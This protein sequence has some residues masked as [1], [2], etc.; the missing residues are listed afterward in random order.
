[1]AAKKGT[2]LFK[3]A[4]QINVGKESIVEVLQNKGYDIVNKATSILTE[5]M[6]GIVFGHFEKELAAVQ[7]QRERVEEKLHVKKSDEHE[8]EEAEA[9]EVAVEPE[10]APAP[11]SEEPSTEPVAAQEAST[12]QVESSDDS[13]NIE[14]PA[15]EVETT[16]PAPPAETSEEQTPVDAAADKDSDVEVGTV[17]KLDAIDDSRRRKKKKADKEQPKAASKDETVKADK[18]ADSATPTSKEPIEATAP[19]VPKIPEVE[20][21]P[22]AKQE[23][24]KESPAPAETKAA[25]QPE[26]TPEKAAT[27]PAAQNKKTPSEEKST[28]DPSKAAASTASETPEAKDSPK[29]SDKLKGKK[30]EATPTAKAKDEAAAKG[31]EE[32]PASAEGSTV[33]PSENSQLKGLTILGKIDVAKKPVKKEKKMRKRKGREVAEA[34]PS[35]ELK[36]DKKRTTKP[37]TRGTGTDATPAGPAASTDSKRGGKK[38]RGRKVKVSEEDVKRKIRE[39][40]AQDE[41]SFG[42]RSKRRKSKR[43]ERAIEREIQREE[44]K[45]KE[46]EIQVTEFLTVGELANLIGVSSNDVIMKC[47]GLGLMV[48]INQRLEKDAIELIASDYNVEVVYQ[49]EFSNE[50]IEDDEDPE[51][52]LQPRP[53]IVTIMGHVDHGKTS[54]LD[55]I[56]DANVVAGEAGGITQHIGAYHVDLPDNKQITFLDTPGHEAFTSMRARG[57]KVTDIVVLIVAAD[58]SV[59]PQTLEAIS[60][61]KAAEVPIVVAINKV[62]KPESNADRIRQ[63]LSERDVLV[64]DWGGKYQVAEVSAKTGQ[65][66]DGLLEKILLEAEVLELQANP[67]RHARGTVIEAHLDKGKGTI[68]T[69]VVEKGTLEVGQP[70][71]AGIYSGRVRAMFDERG[72]KVEKAGPSIPVQILGLEGVPTAGDQIIVMPTEQDARN[73]ANKRQQLRREQDFKQKSHLTL[74]DI[75]EQIKTGGVQTLPI[76]LKGD[77]D[78]SVEALTDALHKLSTEEVK[79]NVIHRGVGG[80]TENDVMLAAASNA[81]VIGFHV[82]P[83]PAAKRLAENDGIDIRMY[84]IIYDCIEEVRLALEGLLRPEVKEETTSVVEVRELFKISRVG[85][86]AGCMVME[87]KI[88]RNDE[89]RLVRDGFE[90]FKG[91]ITSLKRMKDDVKEVETG[92]E[93]GVMLAGFNDLK[94]GDYIESFREVEIARKLD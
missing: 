34:D 59:M 74:D 91:G 87:G 32:A 29:Q 27:T 62:D 53:P 33:S 94:I 5:E 14:V 56:R 93:C 12:P 37:G 89:V 78:G 61:A 21:T 76:V 6:V 85:T 80:I 71:L 72:N 35:G 90:V 24:P 68:A 4:A 44:E 7:K 39:T 36:Y 77:T 45:A 19:E 23:A 48:A 15:A 58:D 70:F 60:H 9:T 49:E 84:S 17:I 42:G 43:Q 20:A 26:E 2:R 8:S 55:Y 52:T 92:F 88:T 54:L 22:V 51:D 18:P 79:V 64:E 31:K 50:I 83:N 11:A 25:K 69:I 67:D 10:E 3:I 13:K 81:V 86:I 75:A 65:G 73:L 40:M 41:P 46:R 57:A 82:R 66:V 47:M 1:M 30:E 16:T 63:Q 28:A 38:K